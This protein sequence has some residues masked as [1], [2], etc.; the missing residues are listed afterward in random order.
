[1]KQWKCSNI[2]INN[3]PPYIFNST[4]SSLSCHKCKKKFRHHKIKSQHYNGR[5]SRN[6][7]QPNYFHIYLVSNNMETY[8]PC[9]WKSF[10]NQKNEKIRNW[11]LLMKIIYLF[12]LNYYFSKKLIC[13]LYTYSLNMQT[14]KSS[15]TYDKKLNFHFTRNYSKRI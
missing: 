2:V 14:T 15:S 1:M 12:F 13:I 7:V 3:T 10:I 9:T 8:Y 4:H 11:G 6:H 5:G